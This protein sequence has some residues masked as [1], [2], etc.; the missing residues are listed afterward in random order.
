MLMIRGFRL[1]EPLRADA[2]ANLDD[3]LNAKKALRRLG[4]FETPEYGLTPYPDRPLFDAV[5]RFQRRE[6][7]AED[8]IMNPG[9]PTEAALDARL[10]K[11]PSV[12]API[13]RERALLLRSGTGG[14]GAPLPMTREVL[15]PGPKSA[16]L[17]GTDGTDSNPSPL[18]RQPETQVAAVPLVV[19]GA[20]IAAAIIG[21][22]IPLTSPEGR[23][24]M[25][26]L[27]RDVERGALKLQDLMLMS[28]LGVRRQR[29]LDPIQERRAT[30]APPPTETFPQADPQPSSPPPLEPPEVPDRQVEVIE[31]TEVDWKPVPGFEPDDLPNLI[32]VLPD[33]SEEFS[34]PIIVEH[35]LGTPRT[36]N[37]NNSVAERVAR[38]V[39]RL[40]LSGKHI[41]G[42]Y[43][44][45]DKTMKRLGEH[46]LPPREGG[47]RGGNFLDV[48]FQSERTGRKLL[49]NTIT[50]YAD[51]WMPEKREFGSEQRILINKETGDIYLAVPKLG[52]E[53]EYDLDHA[54]ELLE[55][56]LVEIDRPYDDEKSVARRIST[57]N[58]RRRSETGRFTIKPRKK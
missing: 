21:M 6:G 31:P 47:R 54:E 20:A 48:A 25:R 46:Y 32:E 8:G 58:V 5:R 18:P 55:D 45:G 19:G 16:D 42:A 4:D 12:R 52:P 28:T 51:G 2:S 13:D 10:K 49:I 43:P 38:V 41:G 56:F 50:T 40:N 15:S 26:Q 1:R 35:R 27:G 17:P 36:Q 11:Q 30:P 22:G 7:L 37:L 23:R 29:K 9:G 14:S 34:K 24:L 3:A 57:S 33:R 39:K 53:E 44:E